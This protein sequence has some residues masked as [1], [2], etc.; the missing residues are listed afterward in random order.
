M[1]NYRDLRVWERAHTLTLAVYKG[2]QC[3]P[4]EERLG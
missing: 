3:F 1:R 4:S 2:M